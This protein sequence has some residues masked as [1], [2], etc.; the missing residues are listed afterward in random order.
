MS[1]GV[2]GLSEKFLTSD[3]PAI[4]DISAMRHHVRA[5]LQDELFDRKSD[6]IELVCVGGT[7]TTLSVLSQTL[8]A[9]NRDLVHGHR[10]SLAETENWLST[11]TAISTAERISRHG[12]RPMRADVF[13]AGIVILAEVMR[14][15]KTDGFVS[16]AFGLRVGVALSALK[17][18]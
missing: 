11:M 17:E 15:M 12:L 1:L 6:N 3:P 16:S 14:H 8:P 18:Q 9:W 13:P 2:V 5:I 4:S 7:A 10:V